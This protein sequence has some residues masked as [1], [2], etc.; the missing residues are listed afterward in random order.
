MT[1][2]SK[3]QPPLDHIAELA[4]AVGRLT[5]MVEILTTTVEDLRQ[6]VQWQNNERSQDYPLPHLPLTKMPLDP[7]AKDW[8]PKFGRDPAPAPLE[9]P[10]APKSIQPRLFG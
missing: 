3:S 4:S 5:D 1:S 9:V 7:T 2:K 10:S 8:H 6:E